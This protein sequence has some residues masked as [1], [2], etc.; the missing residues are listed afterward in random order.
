VAVTR[1]TS[2]LVQ[3]T[4]LRFS[5]CYLVREDDGLTLVDTSLRGS[6]ATILRAAG[7]LGAPIR[8]VALTHAHHDHAGSL[9]ALRAA[10]PDAEFALPAREHRL[11]G[12]RVEHAPGARRGRLRG[13]MFA[14]VELEP[15][16]LLEPGDELGS[17]RAVDASGHTPGQLA[18]LDTR[19][20]TLLCGDAYLAMGRVFVTT[21]LVPRFPMPALLGTWHGPT[22]VRTARALR[23][24]E[25][26]R[27][28]TGHGPVVEDPV[29]AM[30]AALARA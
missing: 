29:A 12:G 11:M 22:A 5:N 1:T 2:R 8:R 10:L 14:R 16:R 19:D 3:I 9:D 23:D 21:E 27:L 6:A 25:P 15:D 13:F 30:D 4:R 18:Y 20:G 26:T 7:E 28:A 17:L 24:L